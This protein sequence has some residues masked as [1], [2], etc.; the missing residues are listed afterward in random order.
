MRHASSHARSRGSV[1]VLM[2]LACLALSPALVADGMD[3]SL[4]LGS[5]FTL[6]GIPGSYPTTFASDLSLGFPGILGPA[7]LSP[8]LK[9]GYMTG[10]M[11]PSSDE[12]TKLDVALGLSLVARATPWL[13]LNASILG[14][15]AYYALRINAGM[16]GNMIAEGASPGIA[17]DLWAELLAGPSMAVGIGCLTSYDF[18]MFLTARPYAGLTLS[19]GKKAA[20]APQGDIQFLSADPAAL[21][22][23]IGGVFP[24]Y[25]KYYDDHALGKV[26][27]ANTGRKAWT[28]IGL[29]FG[30]GK[31]MDGT[32]TLGPLPPLAP[33][34]RRSLDLTALFNESIL[35][36][37]EATK[38]AG[39]L[40]LTYKVGDKSYRLAKAVALRVYDRNAMSWEDDKSAAAFVTAKDPLILG[41]A[42][43]ITGEVN[44][45]RNS[46][47]PDRIQL[48]SAI[49][50]A[51][52][53]YGINYVTDPTNIFSGTK[54]K[55][56]IDF[57]Q[58]PRQTIEY[59]GGD[60]DDLSILYS[61]LFEASGIETAFITVPGH[62]YMAISLGMSPVDARSRIS[63]YRDLI[64]Q[65]EK[66]W[67]PIEITLRKGGFLTAWATGAQEWRE[68]SGKGEAGFFPVHEAWQ[69]YEPVAL[70]GTSAVAVPSFS[71]A[72]AGMKAD[73]SD[74][75]SSEISVR[76]AKLQEEIK[77]AQGGPK[78]RLTNALGCLYAQYGVLDKA[79]PLF[80]S[81][82]D[83][84]DYLPALMNLGSIRKVQGRIDEAVALYDR[85]YKK[86]PK[87][88]P[89]LLALARIQYESENNGAAKRYYRELRDVDPGL[90]DRYAFLEL[91]GEEGARAA[92]ASGLKNAITW[93]EGE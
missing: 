92:E 25:Y 78:T 51:L 54:A 70:P 19:V 47:L 64:F 15:F 5:E 26:T 29:S 21:E 76:V 84:E 35:A 88:A 72:I 2:V 44:A 39:E 61:A 80:Q 81:I 56:E 11:I 69:T 93:V 43:G 50:Q 60:C 30:V 41:F 28:D 63:R 73:M 90:A 33:G 85:A 75:V 32:R 59:K 40:V 1:L 58:F 74:Y 4:N 52:C 18:G 9:L 62:I 13:S 53:I 91:K 71:L 87:S 16:G 27:L 66:T 20:L 38:L 8:Q 46:L 49:H 48:A 68:S 7:W 31:V 22:V 10:Y 45:N 83:R 6:S 23:S 82:V 14:R 37:T 89:L 86:N 55:T 67:L 17:L 24:V 36:S 77:K 79:T 57:L 12:L 42:K 34:E 65:G 3:L